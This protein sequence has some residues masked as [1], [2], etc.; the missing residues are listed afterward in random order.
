MSEGGSP[1]VLF[2]NL[3]RKGAIAFFRKEADSNGDYVFT[4]TGQNARYIADQRD[5]IAESYRLPARISKRRND[6][7]KETTVVNFRVRRA[8]QRLEK[9]KK[10]KIFLK[11]RFSRPRNR[12]PYI[13][14]F[15]LERAEEPKVASNPTKDRPPSA[16]D[17][18]K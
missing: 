4:M 16:K 10:Y 13:V 18:L 5:H 3:I 8:G 12:G 14:S 2:D 1:L 17:F 9:D 15:D 11:P 6:A 7:G